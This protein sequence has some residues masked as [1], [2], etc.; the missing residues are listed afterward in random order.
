MKAKF[1]LVASLALA[2]CSTGAEAACSVDGAR[3]IL[4]GNP[5]FSAIL[6]RVAGTPSAHELILDVHSKDSG[7]TFSFTVNRGNG[8]GDATLAPVRGDLSGSVELYTLDEA[9]EFTDYFG[10]REGLAPKQLL[11]PKLGP[12]LWLQIDALTGVGNSKR[13]RMPRAFFDRVACGPANS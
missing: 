3:Y 12:A 10:D 6:R 8:Y 1:L 7:R 5:D 2:A 4:R 11:A 9:G 13:E